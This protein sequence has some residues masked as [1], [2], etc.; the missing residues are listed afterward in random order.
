MF[1]SVLGYCESYGWLCQN[2]MVIKVC[3]SVSFSL[4]GFRLYS[5][6]DFREPNHPSIN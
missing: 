4:N 1:C 6:R 5:E 3:L 2:G